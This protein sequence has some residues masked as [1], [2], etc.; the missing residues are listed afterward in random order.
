M[1]G[2]EVSEVLEV[3]PA[4]YFVQVIKR[5]KRACKT[6]EEQGVAMAPLPVRIIAKSLVSNRIIIDTI[7]GKYADHNPL[8][9][10]SVIF[11]RDAGIDISRATMCGWVMTVGEMLAQV[12]G[13]MQRE[14]SVY[15]F[16]HFSIFVELRKVVGLRLNFRSPD[17]EAAMWSGQIRFAC[18][19]CPDSWH[20]LAGEDRRQGR[21]QRVHLEP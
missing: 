15:T 7:V 1:I 9:R 18:Y 2:Y 12:V 4:E 16:S 10:Q 3:K 8:Y 20:H 17:V 13:A 14:G 11:L 5:E 6:C 21:A 19:L